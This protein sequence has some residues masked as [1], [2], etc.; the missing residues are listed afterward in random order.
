MKPFISLTFMLFFSQSISAAASCLDDINAEI[1]VAVQSSELDCNQSS[2][3]YLSYCVAKV[4]YDVINNSNNDANAKVNCNVEINYL[5]SVMG[6]RGTDNQ[7][8][9]QI[10]DIAA[11]SN[12]SFAMPVEFNFSTQSE[13]S[14]AEIKA[15][16]C[17]IDS[18]QQ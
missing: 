16:A 6:I 14:K 2:S 13:S 12:D 3:N 7:Y 8:K 11:N 5:K 15:V 10:H 18:I 1:C 4:A 9:S 17:R